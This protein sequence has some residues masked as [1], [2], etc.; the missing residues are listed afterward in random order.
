ESWI[1]F[2]GSPT[3][4]YA[5]VSFVDAKTGAIVG[6]YPYE[7]TIVRGRILRTSDGGET[8]TVQV[9]FVILPPIETVSLVDA[10]IGFALGSGRIF[11]TMDGG[12]S[13]IGRES[14]PS[15]ALGG[16]SFSDAS[17][18]SLVGNHGLIQRTT[19]GGQTWWTQSQGS[20]QTLRGVSFV[21]RNTGTAVGEV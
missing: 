21:D 3:D 13:W 19:D 2:F 9:P 4:T 17:T 20:G 5:G 1:G 12:E 15:E 10:T 6:Y 8:W 18:G 11:R 16:I 7:P 14:N